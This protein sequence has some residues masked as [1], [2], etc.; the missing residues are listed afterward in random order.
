MF[1]SERCNKDALIRINSVL[2]FSYKSF[3]NKQL[4]LSS[5]RRA[6]LNNPKGPFRPNDWKKWIKRFFILLL[7]GFIL[8]VI[9]YSIFYYLE[10]ENFR[11]LVN[12][13]YKMIIN[14]NIYIVSIMT[15]LISGIFMIVYYICE[16]G[17]LSL[18]GKNRYLNYIKSNKVNDNLPLTDFMDSNS[19]SGFGSES[20]SRSDSGSSSDSTEGR[21]GSSNVNSVAQGSQSNANVTP[22]FNKQK[23]KSKIPEKGP[24][25]NQTNELKFWLKDLEKNRGP[26]NYY[27]TVLAYKRRIEW[28]YHFSST[29]EIGNVAESAER[30]EK[31]DLPKFT[32][33]R[34]LSCQHCIKSVPGN[35]IPRTSSSAT[36][37][38]FTSVDQKAESLPGQAQVDFNNSTNTR[39]LDKDKEYGPYKGFF[40]DA[41]LRRYLPYDHKGLTGAIAEKK[42]KLENV[43]FS[44]GNINSVSK[45]GSQGSLAKSLFDCLNHH[46]RLNCQSRNDGLDNYRSTE[47]LSAPITDR[48]LVGFSSEHKNILWM[49]YK[50]LHQHY[51]GGVNISENKKLIVNN[52]EFREFLRSIK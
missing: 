34:N 3:I 27:D 47:N 10:I 43:Q 40:I 11:D 52:K 32:D 41:N 13:I 18:E 4:T 28:G 31:V 9:R 45:V 35:T 33:N 7:T 23:F 20:G 46:A 17:T 22:D 30:N 12:I 44:R 39:T 36:L 5:S 8:Y 14:T 48:D 49:Y 21:G 37:P 19:D 16:E 26:G 38:E 2:L 50:Q 15:S 29:D 42:L 51:K 1:L 25:K 6:T 24:T